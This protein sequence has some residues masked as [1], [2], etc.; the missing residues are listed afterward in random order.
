MSNQGVGL[1]E[2]RNRHIPVSSWFL[3]LVFGW[4][5]YGGGRLGGRLSGAGLEILLPS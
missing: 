2:V 4:C 5:I 1:G 3:G